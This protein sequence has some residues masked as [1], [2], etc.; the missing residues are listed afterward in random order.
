MRYYKA[1]ALGRVL[2]LGEDEIRALTRRGV[3]KDGHAAGDLYILED[4]AREII[5]AMKKPE[6][7][8]QTADYT[9]E[10][11]RLMRVRRQSAEYDLGLREKD[12]H[13]TEDI[14][15]AIL[16][17]LAGFKAKIRAIPS[18]MASQCAKL[19]SK[20]E[21]FDLLK[22]ATDEALLELA[23]LAGV[24]EAADEEKKEN[25]DAAQ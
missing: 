18:R 2:G 24:F 16:K 9:S 6:E 7:R 23:D 17:M 4:S 20:E 15:Q 13:L 12:L 5:A 22:Q 19:S 21:I 10:R 25:R 8:E 11:A 1:A 3:I 14:E